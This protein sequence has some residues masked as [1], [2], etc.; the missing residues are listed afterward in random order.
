M[1]ARKFATTPA[2]E[3]LKQKVLDELLGWSCVDGACSAAGPNQK[4]EVL[5][6]SDF[7]QGPVEEG[8]LGGTSNSVWKAVEEGVLGGTD[9]FVWRPVEASK[10]KWTYNEVYNL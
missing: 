5:A 3:Q 10:I 6:A 4:E 2:G 1:F 7:V 8:V 9:D